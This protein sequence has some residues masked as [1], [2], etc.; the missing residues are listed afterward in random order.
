[1]SPEEARLRIPVPD[2]GWGDSH[3]RDPSDFRRC[4]GLLE[5]VPDMRK[6]LSAMAKVSAVWAAL[7]ARW[8]ELERLY[9]EESPSGRCPKMYALMRELGT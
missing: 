6:H 1:M 9:A 4:M 5:A 3:P 8:D 7:V 2:D